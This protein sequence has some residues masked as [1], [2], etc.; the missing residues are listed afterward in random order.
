M[1]SSRRTFLAGSAA[2]GVGLAVAGGLPSLA[3]A[4]P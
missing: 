3:Q 4:S 1:P 2:A